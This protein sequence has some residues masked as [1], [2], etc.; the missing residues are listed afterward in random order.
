M[1]AEVVAVS[2]GWVRGGSSEES[3]KLTMPLAVWVEL[4]VEV[5]CL[6]AP[7][8]DSLSWHS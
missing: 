7:R 1:V 2:T 5:G 3:V 6:E 8:G 4:E